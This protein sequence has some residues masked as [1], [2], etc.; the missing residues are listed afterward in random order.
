MTFWS[1]PPHPF[2]FNFEPFSVSFVVPIFLFFYPTTPFPLPL[3]TFT[4]HLTYTPPSYSHSLFTILP[5]FTC[6]N[7]HPTHIL[8]YSIHPRTPYSPFPPPL[9]P[10]PLPLQGASAVGLTAGV[11]MDPMTRE[12]TLEGGALVSTHTHI[13]QPVCM[14]HERKRH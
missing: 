8:H 2:L 6:T 11:H 1:F 4:I 5:I 14:T 10:L 9:L 7:P 12:W 3:Y 13:Q